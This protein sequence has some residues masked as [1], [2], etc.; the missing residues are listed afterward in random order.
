MRC[1]RSANRRPRLHDERF[2]GGVVLETF[3][4]GNAPTKP[5]FLGLL[6]EA[7]DKGIFIL[8]VS[9]CDEGRVDQGRYETSKH[10]LDMGIIGGADITTEAAVSKMMYVL[11][12][13]LP[14]ALTRE[15]LCMNLRGEITN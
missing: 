12:L 4:S 6:Q 13:G 3:G 2:T 5:W 1:A 8:N 15:V 11:G 7:L 10:L 14:A 9:Q